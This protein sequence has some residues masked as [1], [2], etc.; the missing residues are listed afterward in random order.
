MRGFILTMLLLLSVAISAQDTIRLMQYNLLMYGNNFGGCTSG[1]NNVANKNEYLK[2]IVN[3]VQPD[4]VFVNELYEEESYHDLILNNVFNINGA[5]NWK[6]G[7]VSNLA[8]SYIV[9]Q[10][11]YNSDIFELANYVAVQTNVRD[12]DIFR[13]LVNPSQKSNADGPIELNCAVAHLK[14][15]TDYEEERGFETNKLLNYMHNSGLDGNFTFSGD[16]NLYSASEQAFQ[17]LLNYANPNVRFYDPINQIGN[18]NNNSFY[19]AIHTQSTHESG[20]CHSGGGMDDRFDFFMLSDEIINGTQKIKFLEGSYHAV[21]QDGEHFNNSIN[22]SPTN[23]SVPADVLNAL[24]AMSDHLPVVI[25][26]VVDANL[27]VN[28][29]SIVDFNFTFNNPASDKLTIHISDNQH[30]SFNI[31]LQSIYGQNMLPTFHTHSS[32]I[33]IDLSGLPKGIYIVK[34][35]KDTTAFMGRKLIVQ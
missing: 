26:I 2:T 35:S 14:A 32:M 1:N 30:S 10:T 8:N 27:K 33:D 4:V 15:G 5:T 6:R 28:E 25:D 3:Y 16:F 9:N 23:S 24:Y 34:L 19:A 29:N 11:F 20:D 31:D 22:G 13:F 18:W 17:N 12:I 7:N 21:G